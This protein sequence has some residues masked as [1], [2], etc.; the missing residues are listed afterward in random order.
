MTQLFRKNLIPILVATTCLAFAACKKGGGGAQAASD[1]MSNLPKDATMVVGINFDKIRSSDLYKEFQGDIQKQIGKELG[2]LKEKCGI[3]ILADLKSMTMSIGKNP[4][5]EK[6][7]FFAVT[8][9]FTKDKVHKCMEDLKAKGEK[10]EF[11][12]EGKLTAYTIEGETA[13]VMW[14]GDNTV[15]TSPGAKS[16][17]VMKKITDGGGSVKDNADVMAM[18]GKADT[19]AMVWMAGGI[20]ND[21]NMEA[22]FGM[23]G[24][25]PKGLY[26]SIDLPGSLDAN[27]GMAF[28]DEATATKAEEALGKQ[29]EEVKGQPMVGA[30]LKDLKMERAGTDV[31]LGIKLSKEDVTTIVT[32]AKSMMG[33]MGG[34]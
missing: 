11:K 23:M 13:Y 12:D 24:G 32:M 7:T 10:V 31:K 33:G 16:A 34:M 9:S 26:L 29:I 15:I 2:E 18:V 25:K 19:G 20:P 4:N 21:P 14:A 1:S 30:Y 27:I 6:D 5:D 17:D 28:A 22:S 3:D 8:G